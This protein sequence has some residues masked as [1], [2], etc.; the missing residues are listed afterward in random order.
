MREWGLRL[1]L[2]PSYL[3]EARDIRVPQRN[4]RTD[5][6]ALNVRSVGACGRHSPRV[7]W[8]RVAHIVDCGLVL[9]A[10]AISHN[11]SDGAVPPVIA[12]KDNALMH[13]QLQTF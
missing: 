8:Q 6:E 7:L 2:R 13:A 4:A 5:K 11:T 3:T 10:T 9:I 1:P 12:P